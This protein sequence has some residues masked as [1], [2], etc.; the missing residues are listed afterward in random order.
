[1][2]WVQ[3]IP[4]YQYCIKYHCNATKADCSNLFINRFVP[5]HIK[6][7]RWLYF[8]KWLTCS[9]FLF[10][11]YMTTL[12]CF[13]TISVCPSVSPSTAPP[14][15]FCKAAISCSAGSE[16]C[17][18]MLTVPFS[19]LSRR[20]QTRLKNLLKAMY[21]CQPLSPSL[22][23][24]LALPSSLCQRSNQS[25]IRFKSSAHTDKNFC[26]KAFLCVL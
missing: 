2:K 16:G 1:M 24:C 25:N 20:K 5:S 8:W 21:F 9:Q 7:L 18:G 11:H 19:L 15:S 10:L 13:S 12:Q 26:W 23:A 22:S 4:V 3:L 14:F 6:L 17:M